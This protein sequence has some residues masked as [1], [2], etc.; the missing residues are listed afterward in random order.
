MKALRLISHLV[1]A[2]FA[3]AAGDPFIGSWKLDASKS[4]FASGD[5]SVIFATARIESIGNDLKST[6]SV[7]DGEGFASDLTFNSPLDG[8]PV[9]VTSAMTMRGAAGIDTISLK[10]VNGHTIAATGTRAGKV[11]YSDVRVVSADGNTMTVSR[12]GT[13]PDGKPYEST[14]ILIRSR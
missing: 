14:L 3:C 1:F 11:V 13:T 7:A 9:K 6:I 12:K 10:R 2:G 4:T 8:T 5:P